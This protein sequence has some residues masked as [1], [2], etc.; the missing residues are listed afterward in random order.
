MLIFYHHGGIWECAVSVPYFL[1]SPSNRSCTCK[2][3]H[4]CECVREHASSSSKW[5]FYHIFDTCTFSPPNALTG[6][7]ASHG[8]QRT[9][10]RRLC[11]WN[12]S[13]ACARSFGVSSG[14]WEMGIFC[15][16][17]RR[18]APVYRGPLPNG[19]PLSNAGDSH[20]IFG[21]CCLCAVSG[22]RIYNVV[23][24][25]WPLWNS[26]D[27][28]YIYTFLRLSPRHLLRCNKWVHRPDDPF[29]EKKRIYLNIV[30]T[31]FHANLVNQVNYCNS[32]TIHNR[33]KSLIA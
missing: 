18:S 12:F 25:T 7:V 17:F 28:I 29:L 33:G 6:V 5:T 1:K 26:L 10:C 22:E 30:T 27:S 24:C 3:W 19:K 20:C 8:Y 11:T 16:K 31:I 13:P 9:C 32:Y 15:R 14:S 23:P 2:V 4:Q 21:I